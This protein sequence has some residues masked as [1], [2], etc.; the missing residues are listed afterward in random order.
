MSQ[1][2]VPSS[3]RQQFAT[4]LKMRRINDDVR[5][6]RALWHFS[7]SSCLQDLH[8]V[9]PSRTKKLALV[10]YLL[11]KRLRTAA[12]CLLDVFD[13]VES[14]DKLSRVEM[15]LQDSFLSS[16]DIYLGSGIGIGVAIGIGI[17]W[18]VSGGSWLRLVML[19]CQVHLCRGLVSSMLQLSRVAI[20]ESK[21]ESL[22]FF[23]L[24]DPFGLLLPKMTLR[25]L[26]CEFHLIVTLPG[27]LLLLYSLFFVPL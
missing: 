1:S 11:T 19:R 21:L 25:F 2:R 7:S 9:S 8:V 13:G 4:L 6:T 16:L 15:M 22:G 10:L 20:F 12:V 5:A 17:R 27:F 26:L 18:A 24:L 3:F 23:Y 14:L